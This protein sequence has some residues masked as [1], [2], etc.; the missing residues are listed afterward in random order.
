MNVYTD[1]KLL[2][3]YGAL[4]SL[5]SLDLNASPSTERNSMRAT[6]TDDTSCFS[7]ATGKSFVAPP[8]GER[9]R[10]LSSHRTLT[11]NEW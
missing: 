10:L 8:V 2:D 9:C 3:V 11:M 5:P 6:G 1:P 4:G 7:G